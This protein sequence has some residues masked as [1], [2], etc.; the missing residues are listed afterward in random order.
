MAWV[1]M[2]GGLW[3]RVCVRIWSVPQMG[4]VDVCGVSFMSTHEATHTGGD[5]SGAPVPWGVREVLKHV[6]TMLFTQKQKFGFS[7]G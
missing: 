7:Y 3:E 6:F 2:N 4:P 5:L 1:G